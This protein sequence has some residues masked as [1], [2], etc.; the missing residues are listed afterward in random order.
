MWVLQ[1][2]RATQHLLEQLF[3]HVSGL[4]QLETDSMLGEDTD[5]MQRRAATKQ[6]TSHHQCMCSPPARA[7]ISEFRVTSFNRALHYLFA[8]RRVL[9]DARMA[10]RC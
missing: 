1:V 8:S 9:A 6:V 2:K 10:S 5:L 3:S 7:W 4:S